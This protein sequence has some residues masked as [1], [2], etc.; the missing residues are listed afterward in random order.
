MRAL[1]R[2]ILTPDISATLL[3]VRGFHK[4][5]PELRNCWRRSARSFLTGYAYA[6]EAARRRRRGAAGATA[7]PIP[8]LRL[9]GRR[10]GLRDA[11][12][13]PAGRRRPRPRVPRRPRRRARLHGVRRHRLGDGPPAPVPRGRARRAWTRC[14]RW[15]VLDGYGFHQAYFRTRRYVHEQYQEDRLPLA[16]ARPARLRQAR[17][18][19]RASAG[20][21]GSSAGTDAARAAEM[22][23]RFP[24]GAPIRPVR[25]HGPGGHLRGRRRRPRAA[26]AVGVRGPAPPDDRAGLLVRLRGQGQGESRGAAQRGRG[27]YLLRHDG[28]GGR[29]DQQGRPAR[30]GGRR[31]PARVRGHGGSGSRPRSRR[32][33]TATPSRQEGPCHDGDHDRHHD[34]AAPHATRPAAHRDAAHAQTTGRRP[35]RAAD[36]GRRTVRRRGSHGDRPE[37]PVLLQPPRPREARPGRQQWQLPQGHRLHRGAPGARRRAADQRRQ[38]WRKQRSTI[39]PVFQAKRIARTGRRR[40]GGGRR[41]G[42]PA[43]RPRGRAADRRDRRVHRVHPRRAR[44]DVARHGSGRVRG[45]RR[46]RSR[47]CRTRPCSRWSPWAWCRCGC[48]CPSNCVSARPRRDLAG[49]V[50]P[51][52]DDRLA[53]PKPDRRRRADPADLL[54]R[55]GVRPRRRP[56]AHARRAG[57]PA[58]GRS[59]NDGQHAELDTAPDRPAAPTSSSGCARR[60]SRCSAT[61]A[62]VYEDLHRLRY[63]LDG[64]AG[65]DAPLPAGVDPDPQGRG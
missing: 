19:T 4:K 55:R 61:G 24:A 3:D 17:R 58:A 10:N 30:T 25:R 18:A 44:Q 49:I 39:Q 26:D 7:D 64:A 14:C 62:P 11:R 56:S 42:R 47:P 2:R 27:T 9:R 41:A 37:D 40:V 35:A 15:L 13:P 57:H 48:R 65:G 46:T 32:T 5:D 50:D 20:R 29:A 8:R 16:E 34:R 31:R 28:R 54:H 53:H 63:T 43:G 12:R 21:C 22:V 33:P 23:D 36:L 59:R 1:R 51:M 6:A 60:R 52:V 38:L 45:H